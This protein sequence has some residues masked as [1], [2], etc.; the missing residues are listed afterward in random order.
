MT[1]LIVEIDLPVKK[2]KLNALA[3]RSAPLGQL[4]APEAV[5]LTAHT[6][7]VDIAVLQGINRRELVAGA[8]SLL[9][10]AV[11]AGMPASVFAQQ[12]VPSLA[13]LD[14]ASAGSFRAMVQGAFKTPAATDLALDLRSHAQ[15]ADAMAQSIVDGSLQ[16]DVFIP[17]TAEPMGTVLRA[18]KAQSARA[19]ARTEMVIVYSPNSR[20][21]AQFDTAARGQANWWEILQEPGLR[22]ARSNPAADPS[23]RSIIFS[24][25]LAAKK[26]GQPDLVAKVLGPTLNPEQIL[27]T[28]SNIETMLASGELD[29]IASYKIGAFAR[30]LHYLSLPSDV[31]LSRQD[32]HAAHPELML[33]IG[34]KTFYPEPLVFYVAVLHGAT[35]PRGAAAFA[36]WLQGQEAQTLLRRYEFDPAGGA[37]DLHV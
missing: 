17:I 14:V 23:G 34:E 4:S 13:A 1:I 28:G 8:G 6:R 27:K 7:G 3:A 33:S 2:V 22:F 20:F 30:N 5:V 32:V 37:P 35:N 9:A 19:I 24:L 29:A 21:V 10:G 16:A 25:M 18:G 26:Y 15:G 12:S 11:T 31:N 36:Q